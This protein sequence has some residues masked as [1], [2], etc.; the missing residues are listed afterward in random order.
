VAELGLRY[1]V[2]TSVDRDDLTDGGAD[3]IARTIERLRTVSTVHGIEALVPD[4]S[5]RR[6]SLDR[7]LNAGAD[8][9]GHNLETVRRI[10]MELRDPRATYDQSLDVLRYAADRSSTAKIKSGLMVGLGETADE[11]LQAMRDLRKAGVH[12]LTIGQYLQPS[13]DAVPVARYVQPEEFDEMAEHARELGFESVAAGP[14]VRSSY[15]AA[16]IL[17]D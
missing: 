17:P 7:V 10:S 4:F 5:G 9:V 3:L 15:H 2:L 16:D 8:V 12:I 11:I 1:V 6:A 14:L 13:T